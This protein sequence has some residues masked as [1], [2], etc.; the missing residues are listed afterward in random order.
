MKKP[1]ARQ[2][3]AAFDL[4]GA[5]GEAGW[6]EADR[7]LAVA[8]AESAALETAIAKLSR[9]KGPAAIQR[10]QDAFALLTQALDTVSRKRGVARFGEVGAVERYDPERHE[11]A[12]AA[13]K[14]APVKL[15]A[16]GVLKGGEVLVKARAKLAA[17]RKS[18]AKRNK[19]AKSKPAKAK[20]GR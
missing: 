15:V 11:I 8:L 20:P 13:R 1:K 2:K 16:P 6:A 3:R 4:V 19:A 9:S 7:A 14:S 5:L 12:V 18:A 17:A 10:T